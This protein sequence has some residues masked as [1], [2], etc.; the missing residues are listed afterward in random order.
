[1]REGAEIANPGMDVE[2]A[3][4]RDAQ[5]AVE[6]VRA[7]RVIALADADA[8]DLVAGA[9]SGA[10]LLLL[11]VEH[12][13]GLIERLL[14]EG[15]RER[16][17]IGA[18][19]AARV[20]R[21][22]LADRDAVDLQLAR[23]LVHDWLDD[24]HELVLARTALRA[25]GWRVG[26]HRH[27]AIAHGGGLVEDRE[28]VAGGTEVAGALMRPGLLHDVEIGGEN[29]A[30]GREAKLETALEARPRAA[31]RVFLGARDAV[32]HR[33]ADLLRHQGGN[34]HIGIAGDL[35]AE[36]AAAEFRDE[37]QVLGRNADEAG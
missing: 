30:V 36:T 4:R 1:M 24:G 31:D 19:L 22:D 23:H 3:V 2:L 32:H 7:G 33:T 25:R 26:Q 16:A 27:A 5:E 13:G 11:P 34:R 37:D 10:D 21:V 14:D 20:G 9:L 15:R 29:L 28:A 6:A 18:D 17:A 8:G 35:A 12:G